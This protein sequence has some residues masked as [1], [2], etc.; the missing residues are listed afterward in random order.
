MFFPGRRAWREYTKLAELR[1]NEKILYEEYDVKIVEHIPRSKA[2]RK[3]YVKITNQRILSFRRNSP[4]GIVNY[5][6][7]EDWTPESKWVHFHPLY[8]INID[9]TDIS[10]DKDKK[11][12]ECLIITSKEGPYTIKRQYFFKDIDAV[13]KIFL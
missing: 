7:K 2:W 12:K 6:I 10:F 1:P 3:D 8:F 5:V 9:K 13:K 11:G 4:T